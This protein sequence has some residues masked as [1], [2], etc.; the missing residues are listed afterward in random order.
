MRWTMQS[1][2]TATRKASS[3]TLVVA[4]GH[5]TIS[6]DS[7]VLS[8]IHWMI[9]GPCVSKSAPPLTHLR[10]VLSG[11]WKV[12]KSINSCIRLADAAS[13]LSPRQMPST[14]QPSICSKDLAGPS[15]LVTPSST[16][17]LL[18]VRDVRSGVMK[19]DLAST[20]AEFSMNPYRKNASTCAHAS[21]PCSTCCPSWM[22][23]S[24]LGSSCSCLAASSSGLASVGGHG[25]MNLKGKG[26]DS[27]SE[28]PCSGLVPT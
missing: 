15:S 2:A 12:T 17:T 23:A 20:E 27:S 10:V 13:P 1:I 6:C 9:W 5:T 21:W 22:S 7:L 26:C 24:T 8:K 4:R 11:A 14:V 16:K 25:L 19:V 28:N 3:P 18:D